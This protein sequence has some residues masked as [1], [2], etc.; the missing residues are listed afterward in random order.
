LLSRGVAAVTQF[1]LSEPICGLTQHI[2]HV[3]AGLG[4]NLLC[5]HCYSSSGPA[6]KMRLDTGIVCQAL[7]D[8][9]KLGYQVAAF[10]GG[11][12]TMHPGLVEMLKHAHS[13]GLRTIMTTNGTLLTAA[14]VSQLEGCLDLLAISL[15]GQPEL[16]NRMRGSETSFSR[17][18]KGLDQVKR[19]RIPYGFIF[20][21]TEESWEHLVWAGEFAMEHGAKLLQVHPLEKMGRAESLGDIA[22]GPE[23]LAKAYLLTLAIQQR[24][25]NALRVQFDVF[26]RDHLM[27]Q[28]K[29][30]YADEKWNLDCAVKPAA[31]LNL[32]VLEA[33]GAV[34]PFAYG[35]SRQYQI[36]NVHEQRL[37]KAFPVFLATAYYRLLELCARVFQ[38]QIVPTDFPLLNWYE[39]IVQAS[40]E[41]IEPV[42]AYKAATAM[43]RS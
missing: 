33:D 26:N 43:G 4:C 6:M 36:A 39:L 20:T 7:S 23:V 34:V 25:K 37:A 16:H 22:P 19:S 30:V 12:P 8:A 2:I 28:P 24:F 41:C 13:S 18:L 15:D 42:P 5:K 9:V 10:S 11:E 35:F 3:H 29:T 14:L 1:S 32:I 17:M 31:A 38:K 40:R 21:L 27:Q